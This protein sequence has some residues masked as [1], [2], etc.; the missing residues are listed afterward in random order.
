ML[1]KLLANFKEH[2]KNHKSYIINVFLY[3]SVIQLG[4]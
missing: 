1:K 4:A 2:V 3:Y